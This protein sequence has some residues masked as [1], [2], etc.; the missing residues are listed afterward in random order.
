MRKQDSG[1]SDR[2]DR[3]RRDARHPDSLPVPA[4]LC[5]HAHCVVLSPGGAGAAVAGFG[6]GGRGF[7]RLEPLLEALTG[8]LEKDDLVLVKGSRSAG[9]E[10]VVGLLADPGEN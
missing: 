8:S 3:A 4:D 7:D 1:D 2:A 9:M 5:S 10:R 6:P